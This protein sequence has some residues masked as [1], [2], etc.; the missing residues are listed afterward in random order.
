LQAKTIE[1]TNKQTKTT[2]QTNKQTK[3]KQQTDKQTTNKQTNKLR[4]FWLQDLTSFLFRLR[5]LDFIQTSKWTW[6]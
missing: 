3:N 2:K 6:Q 5:R 1:Q 4:A